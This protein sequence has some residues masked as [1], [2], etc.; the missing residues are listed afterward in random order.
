MFAKTKLETCLRTT[1]S[2][3]RSCR[4]S[5]GENRSMNA[6]VSVSAIFPLALNGRL[7]LLLGKTQFCSKNVHCLSFL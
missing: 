6:G 5:G 4:T 2:Y 1:G 7:Y 3:F